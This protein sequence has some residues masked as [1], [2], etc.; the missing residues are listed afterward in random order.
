MKTS[1]INVI[2]IMILFS[3]IIHAQDWARWTADSTRIQIV[4]TKDGSRIRAFVLDIN[5]ERVTVKIYSETIDLPTD[6]IQ[7]IKIED[8]VVL[9]QEGRTKLLI[10]ST[11][12]TLGYYAWGIPAALHIKNQRALAA[13]YLFLSAGGFFLPY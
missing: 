12:L 5:P 4:K 13:G 7:S 11:T 2:G 1:W 9:D 8:R 6:S 3:G 10:T